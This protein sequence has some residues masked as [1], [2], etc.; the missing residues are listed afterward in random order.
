MI[1]KTI[2]H[3]K[4]GTYLPITENWIYGQ[5]KNLTQYKPIVYCLDTQNLDVYPVKYIRSLNF[6]RGKI[7]PAVFFNKLWNKLFGFYPT[8]AFYLSK[9]RPDLVHAHYGPGGYSFL[10]LKKMFKL[11]LITTFYGYDVSRLARDKAWLGKYKILFKQGNLFL[12]EGPYMKSRLIELGCP[13]SKIKIQRIAIPLNKIS[14]RERLPKKQGEN[15]IFIFS[16]RFVE[17]KGLIYALQAFKEIRKELSNFEFRIIG[18]GP[19]KN[20]LLDY[21]KTNLMDAYVKFLGF[22]PYEEYLKE[23]AKADIFIHPSV[24]AS[25][26]DSEGGAPTTILEAQAMGMPVIATYH[27]DIPNVTLPGR[28]ALLS[29]E[30]DIASLGE[31][32]KQLLV[33]QNSWSQMGKE[34]RGFVKENHD[35]RIEIENLENIYKNILSKSHE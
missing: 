27:A 1:M 7:H 4:N 22:L 28:S 29:K 30:K 6:K 17:K 5:I 34:G 2:V 18:D 14:F 10:F 16:G 3:Y 9:D 19:L 20:M 33:N 21:V 24:T 15:V 26:G 31:N 13:E 11:P 25:D 8:F 32:I 23:M 12:V 35:I